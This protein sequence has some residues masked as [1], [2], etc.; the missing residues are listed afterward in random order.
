MCT[1]FSTKPTTNEYSV[2]REITFQRDIELVIGM[3]G[4]KYNVH[5]LIREIS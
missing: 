4:W 2:K 1:E 3:Y 5:I